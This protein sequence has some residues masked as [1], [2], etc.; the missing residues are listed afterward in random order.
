MV[1]NE[2]LPD[3]AKAK[4]DADECLFALAKQRRDSGST[5]Q[6]ITLRPGQLTDGPPLGKVSLAHTRGKERLVELMLLMLL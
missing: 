1:N 4:V 3:Y 2:V 5:F 6:D